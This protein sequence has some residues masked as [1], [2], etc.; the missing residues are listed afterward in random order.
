[1]NKS[2]ELS[3]LEFQ[4]LR[5]LR[6]ETNTGKSLRFSKI[7]KDLKKNDFLVD[8]ALKR[9]VEKKLIEHYKTGSEKGYRFTSQNTQTKRK[10]DLRHKVAK[11]VALN[12]VTM[13][14]RMTN[15]EDVVLDKGALLI[16]ISDREYEARA[17][18]FESILK[19]VPELKKKLQGKTRDNLLL[20]IPINKEDETHGHN[21]Q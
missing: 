7:A 16:G 21:K 17:G 13:L 4:I 18:E 1:M 3:D 12:E 2:L 8:R 9:L 5:M 19:A 15:S 14:A 11:I 6:S 10:T 20:I